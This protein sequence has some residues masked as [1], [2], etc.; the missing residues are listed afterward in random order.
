M[1]LAGAGAV[2]ALGWLAAPVYGRRVALAAAA[3]LAVMTWQ[4]NFSRIAFNAALSLPV[5][6]LALG[7]LLRGLATGRARWYVWA[8]ALFGLGFQLYYISRAWLGLSLLLLVYRLLT[9]RGLWA[10][11]WRG[12]LAAGVALL[13]AAAPVL[14]YAATE[15]ADYLARASSVSLSHAIQEAGSL[16]P[17]FDNLSAHLRMWNETGDPNGRHNLPGARLLDPITAALLPC[18][19]ALALALAWRARRARGRHVALPAAGR[20]PAGAAGGG[21]PFF[22]RREPAGAAHARR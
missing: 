5:D 11:A 14:V 19:L 10:R 15:P 18:G 20:G 17:L 7:C 21:R 6:A 16:A 9:E 3:L 22:A 4:I 13:I 12:L 8:G 2:I 1:A